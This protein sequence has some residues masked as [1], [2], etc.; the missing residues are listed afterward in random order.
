MDSLGSI[1]TYLSQIKSELNIDKL[2]FGVDVF[3]IFRPQDK[4]QS[5]P[6]I[7]SIK[8]Y[9]PHRNAIAEF[10][11]LRDKLYSPL[12]RQQYWENLTRDRPRIEGFY[13]L[14]RKT[15][16]AETLKNIWFCQDF[17]TVF[18][19]N[20]NAMEQKETEVVTSENTEKPEP[21]ENSESNQPKEISIES[22]YCYG[23]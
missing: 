10:T 12:F 23:C 14:L 19:P 4:P 22:V 5:K 15:P 7:L 3:H 17:R 16:T 9:L 18:S 1:H 11:Q 20:N 13:T 2:L 21:N 6:Q 8:R